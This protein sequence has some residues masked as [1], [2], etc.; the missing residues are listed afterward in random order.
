[1][2]NDSERFLTVA[3]LMSSLRDKLKFPTKGNSG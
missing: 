1:M 2:L 3:V